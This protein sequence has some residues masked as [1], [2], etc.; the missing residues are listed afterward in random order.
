MRSYRSNESCP[1]SGFQA[2]NCGALSAHSLPSAVLLA[3]A[4]LMTAFAIV[5]AADWPTFGGDAAR[6]HRA[7]EP[8]KLPLRRGWVH[9]PRHAPAPARYGTQVRPGFLPPVSYDHAYAFAVAGGRLFYASSTEGAVVCLD[10][11]SG[12]ERWRFYA[13]GAVRLAPTVS[14]GRVYF[15]ADDGVVYCLDA[16]DG[17]T[18]WEFRAA[19]ARRMVIGHGRLMSQWPVRTGVTVYEG[20]AYFAAGL[21]PTQGVHLFALDAAD[22]GLRWK[23]ESPY[24]AESYILATEKHLWVPTGRTAPAAFRR[25]DGEPLERKNVAYKRAGGGGYPR[26]LAG[27]VV[28]GPSEY[29]I[30]TVRVRGLQVEKP[31][32]GRRF[33]KGAYPDAVGIACRQTVAD[34]ETCYV[35]RLA[36][37]SGRYLREEFR[38]DLCAIPRQ[39]F[40]KTMMARLQRS[41]PTDRKYYLGKTGDGLRVKEHPAVGRALT[42]A[43]SWRVEDVPASALL[44]AGETLFAGGEGCVVAYEAATGRETWRAEVE[45]EAH[46]LAVADGS[47]YAS[48]SAG[49]I[50]RFGTGAPVA[51]A[52]PAARA[53]RD[54]SPPAVADRALA[55]TAGRK[56]F[57][58]VLGEDAVAVAS[59]IAEESEFRIVIPVADPQAARRARERL[60][61]AGLY[62][63]RVVV[64]T[65]S[66]PLPY[67]SYFANLIV[68]AGGWDA[69]DARQVW[70]TLRPHGGVLVLADDSGGSAL[71]EWAGD[72]LPGLQIG[73]LGTVTRGA[74][75]G[76]GEWTH[77]YAD[78][79]QTSNSRDTRIGTEFVTQWFG[80]PGPERFQDRHHI[81]ASPVYKDGRLFVLGRNYLTVVDA[82]NGAYLWTREVPDSS[83]LIASHDANP[84]CVDERHLYVASGPECRVLDVASGD[85]VRTLTGPRTDR[86]WGLVATHGG[87][88]LGTNQHPDASFNNVEAPNRQPLLYEPRCGRSRPI[89]S[90]NLFAVG[91]SD[92]RRV[93]EYT[94]G[95]ILNPSVTVGRSRIFFVESLNDAAMNAEK[96]RVD[97]ADF[98]EQDA[99]LV[100]L[101]LATG[102]E[103]WRQPL[104]QKA[105]FIL[106][107]T[108]ADDTLLCTTTYLEDE[109]AQP[110]IAIY[111]VSAWDPATGRRR[112]RTAMNS[113]ARVLPNTTDHNGSIQHP[114]AIGG[115]LYFNPWITHNVPICEIATGRD[116]SDAEFGGSRRCMPF[117]ASERC[118]FFREEVCKGYD[119]ADGRKVPLTMVSRPGCWITMLPAGGLL[120]MPEGSVGCI[121]GYS[122]QTTIVLCPAADGPAK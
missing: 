50:Y 12:D 52:A 88:L 85:T 86:H 78:A 65:V 61:A 18:V 5:Q 20:T 96:G 106:Y 3:V 43:E 8:P 72:D 13:N 44:L 95:A 115:G 99:Y 91:R 74:L 62:G 103:E 112:W 46:G 37:G 100:A 97:M 60:Q 111:D 101:D 9:R 80:P 27:M 59:R 24:P 53:A 34:D 32:K 114:A 26:A 49:L 73:F 117:S 64:H 39:A 33:T 14:E 67:P 42:E 71:R 69:F 77:M 120:M 41:L 119:T 25:S 54:V 105:R 87:Y 58:M 110:P 89:V 113:R 116:V 83:R 36:T 70:R 94:G 10:A 15:G 47:L 23:R 104:D 66:R 57:C 51:P 84:M 6:T 98:I 22:G 92:F 56:G 16:D 118:L 48:T 109:A 93:W 11:D 102:R 108:Y 31:E 30:S 7:A 17:E 121:C 107:L 29:G 79:Q 55:E 82:Y 45:G 28:Y 4:L 122:M 21:F 76:A 63:P 19:P 1:V 2:G 90:D 75:D 38:C 40:E 81:P 68:S 35:L